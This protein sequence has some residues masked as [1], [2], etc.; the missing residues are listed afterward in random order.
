VR[1]EAQG[2]ALSVTATDLDGWITAVTAVKGAVSGAACID[3]RRLFDV[4][5]TVP[6]GA[7]I[8]IDTAEPRAVVTA[9]R[10]RFLLG[11][12]PIIDFPLTAMEN[13]EALDIPAA[14]LLEA[15]NIGASTMGEDK[16]RLYHAYPVDTHR[17][18]L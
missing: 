13:G 10:S 17:Y 12:L 2:D 14:A 6:D 1:L 11:Q 4:S 15:L 8:G 7:E 5:R 18:L 16:V 3:G 9:G